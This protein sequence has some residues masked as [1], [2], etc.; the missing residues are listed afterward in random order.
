VVFDD[1]HAARALEFINTADDGALRRA[2]VYGRGVN[3]ILDNRP[4]SDLESF[5]AVPYIGTKTV[6]AVARATQE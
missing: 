2:G 5:G 3:I 1:A 6:E 4:F